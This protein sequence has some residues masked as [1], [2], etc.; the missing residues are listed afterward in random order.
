LSEASR[1]KVRGRKL[2]AGSI[3]RRNI[4]SVA[5]FLEAGA[6]FATVVSG[7]ENGIA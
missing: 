5:G 6:G 1:A 3:V 2:M 4:T 7:R